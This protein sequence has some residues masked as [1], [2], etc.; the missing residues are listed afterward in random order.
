MVDFI[1]DY[2]KTMEHHPVLPA[3]SLQVDLTVH[4]ACQQAGKVAKALAASHHHIH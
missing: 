1:C 2:H 3:E 4:E